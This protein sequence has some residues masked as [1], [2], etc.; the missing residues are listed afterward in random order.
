[1]QVRG[2][3]KILVI[4]G[5]P[6]IGDIL[7]ASPVLRAIYGY[8]NDVEFTLFARKIPSLSSVFNI[9]PHCERVVFY[10]KNREHKSNLSFFRLC[11]SL[12]KEKFDLA[13]VLHHSPRNSI[14]SFLSNAKNRIG[15]D[16]GINKIF[17]TKHIA[18]NEDQNIIYYYADILKTIGIKEFDPKPWI[19]KQNV[20][21]VKNRIVFS[22]GSSW[23][24][25]E[26]PP[27]NFAFLA[28]MLYKAG[29][30]IILVGSEKDIEKANIIKSNS[31][32]T[33]MVNKTKD[34]LD[35][36]KIIE[37]S[38]LLICPDTASL[39]IARGLGTKTIS[40]F[41]PTSPLIYGPLPE[42][43]A[44][45]KTIYSNLPC[46][47]KCIDRECS[48]NLCMKRITPDEVYKKAIKALS[49]NQ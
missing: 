22:I 4:F 5:Y 21:K 10:D 35:L 48:D 18:P 28:N 37:S 3:T 19:I 25:K 39:H 6:G 13:V 38:N 42:E 36:C 44:D 30:E 46:S 8:Y 40:L 15:F 14:V 1:M 27:E 23:Y 11:V 12:R 47:N 29:Y 32:V 41:G 17:L 34:L 43:K 33:N 9:I 45:H 49:S 7:L 26:W 24:R 16:Y 31:I 2:K 20:K